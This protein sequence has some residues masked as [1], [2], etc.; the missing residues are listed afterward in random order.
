MIS[1]LQKD[2]DMF[3]GK[4]SRA[5]RKLQFLDSSRVRR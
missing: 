5:I 3:Y 2:M 4:E 1:Y